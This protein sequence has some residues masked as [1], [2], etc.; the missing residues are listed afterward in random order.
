MNVLSDDADDRDMR[1]RQLAKRLVLLR[2]RTQ[3]I[4]RFTGYTRDRLAT[5]RKRL[6]IGS[7]GRHRG[8][9]PT[10]FAIFFRPPLAREVGSA[11]LLCELF[12]ALSPLP[13]RGIRDCLADLE[14]GEQLCEVYEAFSACCPVSAFEFEHLVLLATGLSGRECIAL[15]SCSVCSAAIV[16]DRLGA[17]PRI[18]TC[19]QLR[20]TERTER[21]GVVKPLRQDSGDGADENGH[22]GVSLPDGNGP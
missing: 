11:A 14:W 6:K 2:A 5:L 7:E 15:S 13:H 3:T 21:P 17:R 20:A 9:S 8:P 22:K 16:V 19:C 10:S 4:Y 1:R 18:C 12:G